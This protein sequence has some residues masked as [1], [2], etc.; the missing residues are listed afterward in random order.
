MTLTEQIN[1][2]FTLD[3]YFM[4]KLPASYLT[5]AAFHFFNNHMERHILFS[6]K[7]VHIIGIK[8]KN[9][10]GDGINC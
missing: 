8:Q 1:K 3:T 2:N 10:E 4:E 9:I 6:K 5:P 7:K